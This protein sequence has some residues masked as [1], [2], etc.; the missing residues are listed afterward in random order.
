MSAL[1]PMPDEF[2]PTR[3]TL[4]AYAHAIGAVPRALGVAHPKWWHISLKVDPRGFRTDN[5]ATAGGGVA[6]IVLDL[7]AHEAVVETSADHRHSVPLDEGLTGTEFGDRL[8]SFLETVGVDA[9]YNRAKFENDDPREY[10]AT[11]AT[12][13]FRVMAAVS[14]IF[15][16]HQ[17]NLDGSVGPVQLWPHG[18]DMACEWF[19]SRVET[20]EENGETTDYPSQINLGFYPGGRPYLYSNPWPFESE[21]L[22]GTALPG[23][24]TWHTDGWQGTEMFYDEIQA[25]PDADQLVREFAQA[26]FEV[27]SP[28][29]TV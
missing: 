2:E 23:P 1:P 5:F 29:L 28:T 3:A 27:A 11:K 14:Q 4:H 15:E 26:V 8:I 17:A 6:R 21:V 22:L 19:G 13:F 16:E 9:E 18:F 7:L 25:R 10:D 12:A 20:F 24:A